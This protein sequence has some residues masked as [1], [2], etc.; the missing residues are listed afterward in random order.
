MFIYFSLIFFAGVTSLYGNFSVFQKQ[1]LIA[2]LIGHSV[3]P[4]VIASLVV[5]FE[6]S[7]LATFLF[8]LFFSFLS[9]SILNYLKSNPKLDTAA[10]M[11]I[12]LSGFF[13]LGSIFLSIL[14]TKSSIA[15]S[16]ASD[17]FYGNV[18]AI[19][20]SDLNVIFFISLILLIIYIFIRR[21]LIS[22]TFDSNFSKLKIQ[23][24]YKTQYLFYLCLTLLVTLSIN[25]IGIILTTGLF[26]IPCIVSNL[27]AKNYLQLELI[28]VL[29]S[30]LS[31]FF[32][33]FISSNF[34]KIPTG[35]VIIIACFICFIISRV[36]N[37][38]FI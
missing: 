1:G 3:F 28:S 26:V 29:V 17:I 6:R 8:A 22:I 25:V 7:Y 16:G 20:N 24:A 11:A 34:N 12:V 23:N 37:N 10:V 32:G 30:Q 36:F 27:Y 14:K 13:G 33:V 31:V 38:K 21:F 35:P 19:S 15:L 5:D 18:S 4:A 9:F 2:D